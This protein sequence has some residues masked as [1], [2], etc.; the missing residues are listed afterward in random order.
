MPTPAG[1]SVGTRGW[2]SSS[3]H[4]P[5]LMSP[6]RPPNTPP[7]SPSLGPGSKDNCFQ[8][9]TV[10]KSS[11]QTKRNKQNQTCFHALSPWSQRGSERQWPTSPSRPRPG[12]LSLGKTWGEPRRP[13]GPEDL[14]P[15]WWLPWCPWEGRQGW[16]FPRCYGEQSCATATTSTCRSCL[17]SLTLPR[18]L[19]GW[20]AWE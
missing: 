5:F 4:T 11:A 6:E 18:P 20:S 16:W 13:G 8:L 2:D 19:A 3:W 12:Q 9:I 10:I 14:L 17:G 1:T 7:T 15:D